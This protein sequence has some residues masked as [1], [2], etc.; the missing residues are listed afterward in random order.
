MRGHIKHPVKASDNQRVFRAQRKQ[1]FE[2][3]MCTMDH[4]Q[5]AKHE[6]TL[7]TTHD[8]TRPLHQL[9]SRLSQS[10]ININVSKALTDN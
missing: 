9:V 7:T 4:F 5:N 3:K 6:E 10:T 2:L 8:R 1:E